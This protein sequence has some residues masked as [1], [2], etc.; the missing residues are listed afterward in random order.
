MRLSLPLPDA[1]QP[2]HQGVS[3]D[4]LDIWSLQTFRLLTWAKSALNAVQE[5]PDAPQAA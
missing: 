4:G 5:T 3:D 1:K 2:L